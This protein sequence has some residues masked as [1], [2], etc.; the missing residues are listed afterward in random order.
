MMITHYTY[1]S[2]PNGIRELTSA[3]DLSACSVES[4]RKLVHASINSGEL[5][6]KA[7]ASEIGWTR[8][9]LAEYVANRKSIQ[10]HMDDPRR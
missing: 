7:P 5:L 10:D 2:G 8:K 3:L 4:M 6:A 1:L 9:S